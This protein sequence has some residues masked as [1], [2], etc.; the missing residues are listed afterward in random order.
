MAAT[1]SLRLILARLLLHQLLDPIVEARLV[2]IALQVA[3]GFPELVELG[4]GFVGHGSTVT[5]HGR[6][7]IVASV[8]SFTIAGTLRN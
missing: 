2:V 7:V 4:F 8:V 5:R 3:R 6:L 1:G